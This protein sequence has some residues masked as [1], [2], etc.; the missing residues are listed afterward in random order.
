MWK[1]SVNLWSVIQYTWNRSLL[2]FHL[3][4]WEREEEHVNVLISAACS[5]SCLQRRTPTHPHTHHLP[6][7]SAWV[8]QPVKAET[9]SA[10]LCAHL[11][12]E[13]S[14]APYNVILTV[15]CH[16]LKHSHFR[17]TLFLGICMH[18]KYSIR[19]LEWVTATLKNTV[20]S[21]FSC[22]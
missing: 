15:L 6:W 11:R 3:R 21:F 8:F 2:L 19:T 7:H 10:R 20:K 5:S 4:R 13:G 17:V 12:S 22:I 1:C 18:C 16:F 9:H 14:Q